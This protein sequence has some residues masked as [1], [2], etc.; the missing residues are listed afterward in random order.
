MRPL[1]R[2]AGAL[3]ATAFALAPSMALAH[4]DHG[5]GGGIVLPPG[6]TLVTLSYDL[7]RYQPISDDRLLEL[8][9]QGQN[10]HGIRE[11]AVPALSVAYGLTRN[12]TLAVRVPYLA[13]RSVNE[14]GEDPDNPE[15]VHRG[16]VYGFGDMTFTG[17]Y[18]VLHDHD[19]GLE[20]SL[21]VG[22]KAPT[23]RKGAVDK[24]GELFE[25]EHQPSS[26]S[27]DG[28][29][30]AAIAKHI[31]LLTLSA[32]AVY[33]VAGPGSQDTTLGDRVSYGVGASYRLWQSSLGAASHGAMHLGAR[34]DGIMRHGGP[35]TD[36]GHDHAHDHGQEPSHAGHLH[37][38]PPGT[39]A[40]DVSLGLNGQWWGKQTI[41]GQTDDNTGGHVL[42]VSPG[43]RLTV[44]RWA[45][46][47]NVGIPV[48][49]DLYGVQSQPSWLLSTGVAVQF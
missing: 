21:T 19:S 45:G 15:V 3:A 31:G 6:T 16:G 1:S 23:G 44:D 13:D 35:H 39:I 41:A 14:T 34:P 2:A 27:W 30:G 4:G 48:A 10:A 43:A 33:G 32:N 26:G 8:S 22:F 47:I 40:L 29:F 28:V 18:E 20:A 49:K 25:T 11:I 12:L 17:T 5:G 9:A 37:T 38:S 24:L 36:D 42:Y 46:F 7:A